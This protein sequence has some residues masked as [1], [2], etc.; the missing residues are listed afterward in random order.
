MKGQQLALHKNTGGIC[1]LGK[2]LQELCKL[3]EEEKKNKDQHETRARN[4]IHLSTLLC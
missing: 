2:Q 4:T 1:Q 3:Q